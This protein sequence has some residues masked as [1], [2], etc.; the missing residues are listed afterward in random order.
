METDKGLTTNSI[1]VLRSTIF[2]NLV[3][4][5]HGVFHLCFGHLGKQL[6]IGSSLGSAGGKVWSVA[7]NSIAVFVVT[8]EGSSMITYSR[9]NEAFVASIE[10]LSFKIAASLTIG[11]VITK[12]TASKISGNTVTRDVFLATVIAM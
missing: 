7:V 6:V 4:F 8:F 10:L 9:S 11:E 2:E 5:T 3:V 12:V 1:E